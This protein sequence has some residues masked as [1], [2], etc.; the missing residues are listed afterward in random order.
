MD[1]ISRGRR[2]RPRRPRLAAS[3]VAGLGTI[4]LATAAFV[5]IAPS[6]QAAPDTLLS[7]GAATSAS[8]SEGAGTGPRYAVD[9]DRGTRWSSGWSDDQWFRVD[10]GESHPIE[11]I[12][13]DW[14]AAYARDYTVAVSD[15]GTNWTV[16]AEVAD[17]NGGV[18][19]F[20]VDTAGRYVKWTGTERATGYGY[21]FH[22]FEVFGDG[23]PVDTGTP[24]W[25]DEVTHHEFQANCTFSHFL[26]DDPIVFPGQPGAS[27]LHTFV[28]NRS[29]NA[30]TTPESLLANTES[31]CTVPQDHS[32]YWFPALYRGDQPIEPD[33]PMTIYYKSGIEDYENVVP[34]PAGLRFVAGDMMA[35]VASFQSA[36][37]AV[38][39]WEC[40]DSTKNWSI[41]DYCAPG[42]E[43]NIRYQSPSCWDGKHLTPQEA[44]HHGGGS[45]MAY[46][47]DGQC[48]E[49]HPVAVPMIEFKIAWPVSGDLS[50]VHLASGS[51]QSWHYDFVNAWDQDVLTA[52][53][54]HCINGG[55]Q[56]N[57][58]GYDQ[59][60]PHRGTVLDENYVLVD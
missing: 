36:P 2:W 33:I 24:G 34:F 42:T 7:L 60:K 14:E 46:P 12:R 18:Q 19:S 54:E 44:S 13:I 9:N 41:P 15:D 5:A 1:H 47:V 11:R 27:H 48:P 58:R 53:V 35:T 23:D 26:K 50:D 28:G 4:A 20:D 29:T 52:L 57:P 39:G 8:S 49:T 17:G 38:E 22:E 55:L 59:Y 45:H 16:V 31:T 37:G 21:S 51:D 25:D 30:F 40:G 32:S 56:C 3:A 43:L 6:A 10:L